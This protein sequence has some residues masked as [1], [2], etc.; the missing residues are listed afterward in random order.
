[1]PLLR[2]IYV[3]AL[4]ASCKHAELIMVE[5]LIGQLISNP[6]PFEVFEAVPFATTQKLP[7]LG[8]TAHASVR[9][10]FAAQIVFQTKLRLS[11]LNGKRVVI[12]PNDYPLLLTALAIVVIVRIN[13]AHRIALQ[14]F[15]LPRP[16]EMLRIDGYAIGERFFFALYHEVCRGLGERVAKR[17]QK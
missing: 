1:M 6:V 8:T 4:L 2:I 10:H 14:Y 16:V 5:Q 12:F 13:V 17:A 9:K 7:F 15:Q 11:I 3:V